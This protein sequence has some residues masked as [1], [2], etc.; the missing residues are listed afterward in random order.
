MRTLTEKI[1]AKEAKIGIMGLGYVGL[2]LAVAFAKKSFEVTGFDVDKQKIRDIQNGIS[3][4]SDVDSSDVLELRN[5]KKISAVAH[6]DLLKEMD[7]I[8]ICVPTPLRKSREPDLSFIAGALEEVKSRIRKG[9]LIILESTTY[10]GTTDEILLPLLSSQ[11]YKVGEDFFLAFSPERVDPGNKTYQIHNTPKVVGGVTS[12]CREVSEFLYSQI[13]EK[14]VSVSSPV[15]AELVKLLENTFRAV[16]IGLINE[17]AIICNKLGVETGEV[18]KAAATK[19]FGFIPFKPGPGLGGH[20]IPV[21][22][23]YLSWKMR[24][25]NYHP[26]FIQLADEINSSMPS[27]VVSRI[28]N[29]LNELGQT[30]KGAKILI[31]GVSYKKDVG[32]CRESP[33][34]DVMAELL[35]MGAEVSYHDSYV[36]KINVSGKEFASQTLTPHFYQ[37]YDCV[38]ILT[39]HSHIDYERLVQESPIVFDTRYV[40]LGCSLDKRIVRL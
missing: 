35:R 15:V 31:M 24:S 23:Q 13:I 22:P 33:A 3:Y 20:C 10:P 2:P 5:Q 26:R 29:V 39:D 7:A 16:N 30:V 14:I 28:G 17:M 40:T 32:D 9:Q 19:P 27:Y 25:L 4:I 1:R 12:Q 37:N 38:T 11:G 18:I 36:P 21:D 6:F 34:F 8:I